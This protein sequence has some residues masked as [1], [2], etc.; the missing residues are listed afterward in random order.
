MEDTI[1]KSNAFRAEVLA[2]VAPKMRP[3]V[4]AVSTRPDSVMSSKNTNPTLP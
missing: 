4:S 1:C 2:D 3:S